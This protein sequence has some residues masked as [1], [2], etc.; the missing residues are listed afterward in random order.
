MKPAF[1]QIILR[2]QAFGDQ[3]GCALLQPYARWDNAL[4]LI[5]TG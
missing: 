4:A 1:Q 2:L 3:L 5:E